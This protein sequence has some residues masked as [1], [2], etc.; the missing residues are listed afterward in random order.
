MSD[1]SPISGAILGFG[2][3]GLPGVFALAAIE[4]TWNP[5]FVDASLD[6]WGWLVAIPGLLTALVGA[7]WGAEERLWHGGVG[8]VGFA[9]VVA[10]GQRDGL[11]PIDELEL[12]VIGIDGATWEQ[13][14]P[15]IRD[16]PELGRLRSDGATGTMHA[17]GPLF[18]PL[19]WTT[20]ATGRPLDAHGVRGFRVHAPDC[21]VPR[22]FDIAEHEGRSIGLYKWLV[23]WPPR[24]PAHGGFVV[25]GWLAPSPET[26]PAD[27]S[28]AKEI[29]L[30]RRLARQRVE[31]RRPAWRL[32]LEGVRHGFRWT[33]LR[34]AAFASVWQRL[35]HPDA[36]AITLHLQL[37]R[38]RMDRDVFVHALGAHR[39]RVATFTYYPTD[40]I[41]HR[42]WRY[43]EPEA[44]AEVDRRGIAR[45][46]DAVGTAYREADTIVGEL[47][48]LL[49]DGARLVV[50]SDHGF[51][52]VDGAAAGVRV[53]P[54]TD[55]L[56]QRIAEVAPGQVARVGARVTVV[57]QDPATRPA[58]E[59]ML[60]GIV[61]QSTGEPLFRWADDPDEP[62]AVVLDLR[63]TAIGRADLAAD[64]A[65]GEPLSAWVRE[66]EDVSGDHTTRGLFAAVGPGVT[67]GA[68]V[69]VALLDVTPV[70]L[71]ALGLPQ[72]ED[73]PGQVPHGLWPPAGT[74]TSW[75][76]VQET[77]FW[78][79][80]DEA[81]VNEELL[82]ALGYLDK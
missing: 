29:E 77:V 69:D 64:R 37:L 68:T 75:D 9:A 18:S 51:Q 47:R 78:P 20:M 56:E 80:D 15:M 60:A 50:V 19:L 62:G 4:A 32:A 49:P 67:P 10:L 40:A 39:P 8:V 82:E 1:R 28:F 6:C 31:A 57:L 42:F 11:A 55:V 79:T 38:G 7:W 34:D 24:T 45:Y 21:R 65:A 2:L 73:M 74:V 63:E 30:S 52:A 43:H 66:L 58:L 27:L 36:D 59:T 70:L 35:A 81:D 16:L 53:G 33:T 14:D 3:G 26:T 71:A 46:G 76:H 61:R 22:F 72:G 23:T 25:P 48:R 41:G 5:A 12:L 44:F 13:V 17:S 54:R